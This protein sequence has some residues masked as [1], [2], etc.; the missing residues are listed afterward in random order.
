[1]EHLEIHQPV[2]AAEASRNDV[3]GLQQLPRFEIQSAEGTPSL[4]E[5]E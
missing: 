2:I 3:V 5:L 1:M 4:L